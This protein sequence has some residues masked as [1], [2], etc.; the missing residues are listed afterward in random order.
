MEYQRHFSRFR[1]DLANEQLWR[2]GE[3]V[4]LRRKTFQVLRHLVAR[5]GELV[6]KEALLDEVWAEA[7]VS[8][9]MPSICVAE[10]REALGDD[11]RAPTLIETVHG[12][13]YRFIAQ[14]ETTAVSAPEPRQSAATSEPAA[15]MVGREAELAQL[16]GWFARIRGSQRRVGFVS[17]EPGIGKTTIVKAFLD[18]IAQEHGIRVGYGQCIEQYGAG[19]PYMPILEA[20]TRLGREANGE[21]LVEAL[22]RFA[23]NWLVQMPA[24]LSEAERGKPQSV[25]QAVTQQRMLREVIQALESIAADSPLALF[26]EDL[27]WSDVSTLELISALARRSESAR[28]LVIG[29]YRP[30]EILGGD[31]PLRTMKGELELHKFCEELRLAPLT[32]EDVAKYLEMRLSGRAGWASL[33]GVPAAIHERTEGNPLFVVNVVDY[34]IEQ[35]SPLDAG[36]IEAPR[37]ILQMIERNLERLTPEEQSVLEA[38]SVAGA[39]F[40]AAAVAAALGRPVGEIEA[41]C[42]RL[43]R[44]ERFVNK[45]GSS[46]WPDGT[47][48][49]SFHFHHALYQ[50]ALY[51]RVPDNHRIELHRRIA[52]REETA[53]G[54]RVG[55]ITAELAHHYGRSNEVE[56]AVEY[57]GSAAQRALSRSAFAEALAHARAGL[58]LIPAL[59]A[60]AERGHR[61]FDLLATQVRAATAIEGWGSPKTTPGYERM[62][63]LARESGD[64]DELMAVLVGSCAAHIVAARY[65]QALEMARQMLIVAK[66]KKSPGALADAHHAKGWTL[67]WT[68]EIGESSAALDRAITLCPDGAGRRTLIGVDPLVESLN[69]AAL[70]SWAAGYPDRASNLSESAIKRASAL[71]EPFSLALSLRCETWVRAWRGELHLARRMSQQLETLA[72]ENDFASP[73]AMSR[74]DEGWV[75]SLQGEYQLGIPLM[76]NG[77]GTWVPEMAAWHQVLLA[78][79][80]IRGGCYQEALDALA[81]YRVKTARTGEHFGQSE[82]ERLEG[83]VLLLKDANNTLEVEQHMRRAVAVAVGQGAKSFELRATRTLARLLRDTG[84]R[85]EACTMLAGIYNWFTEGFDTVDLKDAKSLLDELGK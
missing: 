12:R 18:S 43:S 33:D 38:A 19:E 60:T 54:E 35:G 79:A 44:R 27:H 80:F 46:T 67:F 53:Y 84:R 26:L 22:H 2:G 56:K 63:D 30:A 66:R 47:V 81:T 49:A 8:D 72:K 69:S 74:I 42:T 57:L 13:G 73:L 9:S 32:K 68:G 50:D 64:D 78:Q 76:E 45:Q 40:S 17:G 65:D 85:D 37:N 20:L 23:P 29:T 77:L 34:L 61:E 75:A 70:A 15:I 10:L 58:A 3:K 28:L 11:A 16:H 39:E 55:E 25:A 7:A 41:C 14:V 36:K 83:E 1:L 51:D 82:A 59:A 48:A 62:R 21:P 52:E 4:R 6:T 24:L 71:K 5:P 31:H